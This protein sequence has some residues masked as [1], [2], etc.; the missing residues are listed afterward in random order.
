MTIG[1]L[2]SGIGGLELGLE[3]AGLGR[4]LWQVEIDPFRRSILEKHWPNVRRFND[5]CGVG[6]RQLEPVNVICGGFPCTDVSDASR[7]RGK[8]IE[9]PQ[10]GLWKEFA[11]IVDEL[12]PE[13]VIVENVAGAAK[14]KWLPTVRRDLHMLGYDSAAFE[15]SGFDVGAAFPGKRIF[16]VAT[17]NR[18][19]KPISTLYEKVAELPAHAGTMWN[20]WK[21]EPDTLRMVD[22]IPGGMDRLRALGNA[23]MPQMAEVI[24]RLVV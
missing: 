6:M 23:V 14:R 16:V 11:R 22:G 2:F 17:A 12:L 3:R 8:G 10:S 4:T 13:W 1:S 9:G 21:S 5:V 7:G 15:L 24:G 19:S 20:G 18:E